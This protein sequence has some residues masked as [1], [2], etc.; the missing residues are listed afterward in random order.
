M[1]VCVCMFVCMYVC[2]CVCVCVRVC[3][4]VCVHMH[5]CVCVYCYMCFC[6][7]VQMADPGGWSGAEKSDGDRTP[8]TLVERFEQVRGTSLHN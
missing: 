1:Y 4:R 3:V 8:G 5:A 6:A 2:V 7:C